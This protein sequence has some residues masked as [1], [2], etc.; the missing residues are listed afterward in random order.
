[1]G[2]HR[3]SQAKPKT[4]DTRPQTF[5]STSQ[6]ERHPIVQLQARVGN[7]AV[8]Q[9]LAG[10]R[11]SD[12]LVPPMFRGLSS[13]LIKATSVQ[14]KLEIQEAGD[15]YEQEADQVAAEVVN[16]LHT[17][18]TLPVIQEDTVQQQ[19]LDED[20]LLLKPVGQ[21]QA[22]ESKMEV[23]P[24]VE[25]SIHHARGS[26]QALAEQIRLPMETAFGANFSGVRVHTDSRADQLNRS[27]QAR[28]FTTG[29]DIFF[30]QD[31]YQPSKREGQELIAHELTHVI[32]QDHNL[33]RSQPEIFSQGHQAQ[34]INRYVDGEFGFSSIQRDPI[35]I[36][37]SDEENILK[38]LLTWL[39]KTREAVSN[40]HQAQWTLPQANNIYKALVLM[41]EV[42]GEISI[43][44]VQPTGQITSYNKIQQ[45]QNTK[46]NRFNALNFLFGNLTF[47]NVPNIANHMQ[48]YVNQMFNILKGAGFIGETSADNCMSVAVENQT[49][50]Q[51]DQACRV[52]QN[53][54]KFSI[55]DL[56]QQE[57]NGVG[58]SRLEWLFGDGSLIAIDVPGS[59]APNTYEVNTR[60]HGERRDANGFHLTEEGVIVDPGTA[61]A[62]IKINWKKPERSLHDFIVH[63]RKGAWPYPGE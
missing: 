29:Q 3:L 6:A 31:L 36:P 42:F 21:K 2:H 9:L 19:P 49:F 33:L 24:D 58:R 34:N 15:R 41:T 57:K 27:I 61:A 47:T 62:H 43:S 14:A 63:T 23:A 16:Q 11:H 10:Y 53:F 52:D 7:L 25:R 51:I 20:E 30:R 28:A 35:P 8:H 32:Q 56:G 54:S 37:N 44:A 55:V 5:S 50:T 39:R 13:E 59:N 48:S 26:G 1:M 60:P 17:P 45:L 38:K 40:P 12:R 18:S 46:P 22:D 4:T